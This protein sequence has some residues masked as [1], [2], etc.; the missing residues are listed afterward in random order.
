MFTVLLV[1]Y[2]TLLSPSRLS[3]SEAMAD[4]KRSGFEAIILDRNNDRVGSWSPIGGY[5]YYETPQQA[6]RR[7]AK[8]AVA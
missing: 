7:A 1:N 6:Q 8:L 5:R 2:G 3:M 4:A